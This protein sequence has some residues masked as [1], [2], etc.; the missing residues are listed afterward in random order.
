[1]KPFNI[2]SSENRVG[3]ESGLRYDAVVRMESLQCDLWNG[4]ENAQQDAE[5]QRTPNLYA[6]HALFTAKKEQPNEWR[7]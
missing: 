1:M 4:Q 7:E 2:K 5:C 6:Q 3:N